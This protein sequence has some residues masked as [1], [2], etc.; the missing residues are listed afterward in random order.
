MPGK[1]HRTITQPVELEPETIVWLESLPE[2]VR[3]MALSARFPHVANQIC[4]VWASPLRF[5][6]CMLSLLLDDRGGRQGFP[7]IVASE[8]AALSRH[9]ATLAFE[10]PAASDD[11]RR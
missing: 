7:R 2:S 8:L 1:E 5:D 10:D 3:P 9:H 6:A 4:R 11:W